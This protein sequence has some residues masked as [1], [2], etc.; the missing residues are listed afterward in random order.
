M[1]P[2]DHEGRTV[3]PCPRRTPGYPSPPWCVLTQAPGGGEFA[4]PSLRVKV[5]PR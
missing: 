2:S 3:L 4:V 5:P 1:G